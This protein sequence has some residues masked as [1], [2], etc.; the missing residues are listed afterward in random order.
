M[1]F[2]GW[3]ALLSAMLFIPISKLIWT[4]SIRRQQRKLGR[5]LDEAELAGQMKRARFISFLVI[6][7]F[8]ILFNGNVFGFPGVK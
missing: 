5:F 6:V 3:S 4:L 7:P 1:W 8:A 2:Y